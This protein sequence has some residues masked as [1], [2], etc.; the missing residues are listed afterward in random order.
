MK[1]N[2]RELAEISEALDEVYQAVNGLFVLESAILV[3][4]TEDGSSIT[5]TH[6]DRGW[7]L[8]LK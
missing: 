8:D 4:R 7:V 1:V 5:A 2:A 6:E 3:I